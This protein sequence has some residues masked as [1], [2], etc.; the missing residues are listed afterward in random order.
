M[1]EMNMK[2][3]APEV[4]PPGV[5]D[6]VRY[7]AP[8]GNLS[9]YITPDPHDG[10]KHPAIIWITGGF[11]NS[12]G[13]V[14]D[15]GDAM[16]DQSASAY[17]RAGIVTMYPSLRGGNDH[18]GPAE[19]FFGEVN[20]VI[21][22]AEFLSRQS[23][24]DPARI[25]LGG[26][27]TGGTLVLLVAECTDRF[28]AVFSFGPSDDVRSYSWTARLPEHDRKLRS[29]LYWLSGIRSPTFVMEGTRGDSNVRSLKVMESANKNSR[30][31]FFAV[32][33]RDHFS[34]LAPTNE[35][36]AEKILADQGSESTIDFT[37]LELAN[38][39]IKSDPNDPEVK[40][41][42]VPGRDSPLSP[43][44]AM[45][46]GL[47]GRGSKEVEG[48][49]RNLKST[50]P[51]IEEDSRPRAPVRPGGMSDEAW[52]SKLT[53]EIESLDRSDDSRIREWVKAL[54]ATNDARAIKPI[55]RRV[56]DC[57]PWAEQALEPFG[58][59][60]EGVILT[61]LETAKE[62]EY[63]R[64][65]ADALGRVGTAK[66]L[67]VLERIVKHPYVFAQMAADISMGKIR[68]RLGTR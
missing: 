34:I 45:A 52:L 54:S 30:V 67:P 4:P 27:S 62:Q 12:I 36:L 66:S 15:V 63:V 64:R 26:H 47:A 3:S 5:F 20:D 16:N 32:P 10:Q 38:R 49:R 55:V 53:N 22:A 2:R 14:W 1:I 23:Y 11:C 6:L 13:N 7:P 8:T 41:G 31:R 59:E 24:V 18:A 58:A 60:A 44:E 50:P 48:K 51:Q 40:Q 25:Y 68:S 56:A 37:L 21:A 33:G 65:L 61:E 19:W 29:P 43:L 17:R 46:A 57:Y 28:R 35:L 9:A 39:T 42:K